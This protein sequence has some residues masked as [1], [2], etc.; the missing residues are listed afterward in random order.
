MVKLGVI[1][2]GYWGPNLVRNLFKTKGAEVE[3]CCD[4]LESRLELLKSRYPTLKVTR[5]YKELLNASIDAVLIV[6]PPESHYRLAKEFLLGGKHV[7]VEKPLTFDLAQA[8]ELVVI[9]RKS[10]KI[11]MVGHTFEYNPAVVKIKEYI[12]KDELGKIYYISSRRVNLGIVRSDI[13]AL[14]NLAPHDI[15]ILIYLL[16]MTPEFVR[17][18]G[19]SFLQKN[20]EDVVFLYLHFPGNITAHVHVSWLDPHKVRETVIVGSKKMIAYNELDNEG[21]VKIY[22]KGVDK[23]EINGSQDSIY[24]EFQLNLRMG[25]ILVPKID[26]DEPLRGLSNNIVN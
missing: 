1:G 14:W 11:L 4:L 26:N 23:I 13:N 15:S 25:D 20:I 17:A 16:G 24:K 3:F 12:E 8:E 18:W 9:S 5:D 19:S 22:D 10:G 6:T 7:F 21:R 2:C